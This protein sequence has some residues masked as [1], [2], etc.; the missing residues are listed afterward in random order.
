MELN[1]LYD[2]PEGTLSQRKV[3]YHCEHEHM[4]LSHVGQLSN[5]S[6]TSLKNCNP[7]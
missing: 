3:N 6:C 1:Q 7:K 5:G 4:C 2:F